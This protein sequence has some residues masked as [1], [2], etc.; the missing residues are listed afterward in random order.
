MYTVHV[1]GGFLNVFFMFTGGFLYG[2]YGRHFR[3]SASEEGYCE[4][5]NVS[6]YCIEERKKLTSLISKQ[7]V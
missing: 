3:F 4:G 7:Q 2:F 6:K 5:F 1:I